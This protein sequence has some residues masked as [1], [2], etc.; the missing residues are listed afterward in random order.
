MP[1]MKITWVT[2]SSGLDGLAVELAHEA[3]IAPAEARRVV[4]KGLLNIKED[5]RRRWSGHPHARALPLA[6][7]YDTVFVGQR[8]AGEVGPDKD[9]TQGAL[10][11][12]FEYGSVN[13]APIPG[14]APALKT[15]QPKFERAMEKLGF[16]GGQSW[17]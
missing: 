13:N 7:T 6:I 4:A 11:N 17:R 15:E 10:G 2:G 14:G 5:W 3:R 1:D 9:K 12:L 8:V 16:D